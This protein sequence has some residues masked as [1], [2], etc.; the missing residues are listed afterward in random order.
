MYQKSI[1]IAA[2]TSKGSLSGPET[3]VLRISQWLI[4]AGVDVTVLILHE[5][6]SELDSSLVGFL[7]QADVP[8]RI[9]FRKNIRD[10]TQWYLQ[11]VKSIKPAVFIANHVVAAL[12]ASYN[13]AGSSI[14][15]V[16]LVHS[17]DP[18]YYKLL[19]TFVLGGCRASVD[20]VVVVSEYLENKLSSVLSPFVKVTRIPYGAPHTER[21]VSLNQDFFKIIYV[22]RFAR[23]QKRID[24]VTKAMCLACKS[25]PGVRALMLGDG[26]DRGL[27]EDIIRRENCGEMV[28]IA[29]PFAPELVMDTMAEYN[30]MVLLSD[31]EGIPVALLEGMSLGLVPIVSPIESGI[32][33]LVIDGRTGYIVQDRREAFVDAVRKLKENSE[34]WQRLSTNARIHFRDSFSQESVTARWLN[35][36][37]LEKVRVC[38]AEEVVFPITGWKDFWVDSSIVS[39]KARYKL[40]LTKSLWR[41]WDCIPESSRV[42][43]R[44]LLR[45]NG[46]RLGN[47]KNTN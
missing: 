29:G 26:S 14:V 27:I 36:F 7:K 12:F 28:E 40:L 5:G 44:N 9:K 8:Y 20:Q 21:Q 45:Y 46:F 2:V 25:I 10:D 6:F 11:E 43:A 16:M 35:L 34:L 19:D 15:R 13:L 23:M 22:G 38:V 39:G 37:P 32:P 41:L 18:L 47:K 1:C 33:E 17:D 42:R 24:E 3:W 30:V 31:Y 4:I